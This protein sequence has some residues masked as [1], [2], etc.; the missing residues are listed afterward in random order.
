MRRYLLAIILLL[1][2]LLSGCGKREGEMTSQSANVVNFRAIYLGNA[3]EEGLLELYRQLDELTVG[4]LG[5]TIRFEFIPWGNEREQLNIAIASGEYD[6]IPGGVFS[7]YRILVSRNAPS[8][9]NE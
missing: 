6:F 7:D 9:L 5:C 4:E 3:P 8:D 1:S 2:F